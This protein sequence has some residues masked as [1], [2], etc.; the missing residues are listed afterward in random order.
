MV[1]HSGTS[2]FRRFD[3]IKLFETLTL[4]DLTGFMARKRDKI[5]SCAGEVST[6]QK[7]DV[8]SKGRKGGDLK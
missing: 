4:I 8:T 7:Q 5:P 2:T 3:L 6:A 1:W